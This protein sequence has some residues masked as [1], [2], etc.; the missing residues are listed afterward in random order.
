MTK[1]SFALALKKIE[2][3]SYPWSQVLIKKISVGKQREI[4]QKY[5]ITTDS[6]EESEQAMQA[7]FEM[8]VAWIDSWNFCTEWTSENEEPEMLEINAEALLQMPE[9]DIAMLVY[10]IAWIV[11]PKYKKNE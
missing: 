10:E 7:S 1:V 5:K 8:L 9:E 11:T 4:Q 6:S 3:P 2:L